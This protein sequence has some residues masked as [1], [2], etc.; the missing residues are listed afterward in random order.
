[1]SLEIY[2]TRQAELHSA[3]QPQ[4]AVKICYQAAY[5]AEHMLED[6]SAAEKFLEEELRSVTADASC[7]LYEEISGDYIRINL[8]A[9]KARRMP[10]RWLMN[11]FKATAKPM[12]DGAEKLRENLKA[13]EALLPVLPF[14]KEAWAEYLASYVPRGMPP[15]RH[16]EAYRRAEKPAYRLA[17]KRFVPLL[18]I[19]EKAAAAK[20]RPCIIAI[21]G[22]AASGKST[23]AKELALITEAGTVSMDDFF[24]PFDMR[25]AERLSQ[26]GGNI[27]YERFSEEVLPHIRSDKAFDYPV[28]SC[29]SGSIDGTKNVRAGAVRLVE[30]SYSLHPCFGDYA[31]IKI[32]RDVAADVQLERI[33]KRNGAAMAELFREKWIPMEEKY[34]TSFDIASRCDMII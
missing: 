30:G 7:S 25:S 28:F 23:L 2:L 24:L 8:A 21:D 6:F 29:K 3:M 1:M 17:L 5:G 12:P 27:H 22:R 9:W 34:F 20:N 11:I 19:L 16:S 26:P 33:L 4:D 14:S 18:P 31:D 10:A 32:F 15:V 13:A